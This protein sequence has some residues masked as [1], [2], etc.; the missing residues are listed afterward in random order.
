MD[1]ICLCTVRSY[2]LG[3]DGIFAKWGVVDFAGGIVH[4]TAGFAAIASAL[5]VGKRVV[6][7]DGTH[8]IP[9]IA[10]GAALLWFGW[11]GFNAGSELQVNTVTVSAFVLPILRLHLR[12]L[13]GLLLNATYRQ[14]QTCRFLTG[15]VAG[16][17]T[18]TPASGYVSL[19]LRQL[20]GYCQYRLLYLC[21]LSPTP[22]RRCIRCIRCAR[23]W[24]YYRLDFSRCICINGLECERAS[25]VN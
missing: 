21:F 3:P 6:K 15:A 2:G 8:N 7:S 22:F 14:T 10:L 1:I 17:A 5:Y 20:S 4:A 23:C 16:L 11:Y 19:V 24:W 25:R 12:Q 13:L 18:I 9:Y